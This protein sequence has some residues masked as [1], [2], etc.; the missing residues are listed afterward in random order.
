MKQLHIA[1]DSSEQKPLHRLKQHCG[2][3]IR[4]RR[5][6]LKTFDY[7]LWGDWTVVPKREKVIPN[8]AIER[9]SC[10]DFIGSF[11]NGEHKKRE[12]LKIERAAVWAPLPIVYVGEFGPR[13]I[14][15]YDYSVFQYGRVTPQAVQSRIDKLRFSGVHV[16]LAG[17]RQYAEW[18]IISILKRRAQQLGAVHCR[19]MWEVTNDK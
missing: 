10:G 2:T 16:I 15:A 11:F 18:V 8:F 14:A 5:Q 13:D 6:A 17:N 4:C 7:S 12:A 1:E 3:E 19:K 9:K